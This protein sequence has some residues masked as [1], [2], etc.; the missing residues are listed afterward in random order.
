MKKTDSEIAELKE[1]VKENY[2]LIFITLSCFL[3]LL[4][5]LFNPK[6]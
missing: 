4:A 3:L 1:F 6:F 2:F 5:F